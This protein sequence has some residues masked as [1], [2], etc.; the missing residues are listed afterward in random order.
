MLTDEDRTLLERWK[1][2]YLQSSQTISPGDSHSTVST[3][4]LVDQHTSES[5]SPCLSGLP[6]TKRKVSQDVNHS[7][8][9][10]VINSSFL[11]S[12]VE[13]SVQPSDSSL[14]ETNGSSSCHLSALTPLVFSAVTFP[15]LLPS[16]EVQSSIADLLAQTNPEVQHVKRSPVHLTSLNL[17]SNGHIREG[18]GFNEVMASRLPPSYSEALHALLP[19]TTPLFSSEDVSHGTVNA[20]FLQQNQ[21]C[22]SEVVP[23]GWTCESQSD[24]VPTGWICE[25][26]QRTNDSKVGQVVGEI[27]APGDSDPVSSGSFARDTTSVSDDLH[28]IT[29]RLMK[30]HVDDLTLHHTPRGSGA[31]YGVGC[32][33]PFTAVLLS[34]EL[35]TGQEW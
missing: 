31:G 14:I 6:L 1:S 32:D 7:L 19:T 28:V 13:P 15:A 18:S 21:L 27:C 25:E 26:A 35:C 12:Q 20:R 24:A 2:I 8:Q 34:S 5:S 29:S 11:S 22:Q 3:S 4:D 33:E 9:G 17:S 30:S 23:T 16:T 10:Q